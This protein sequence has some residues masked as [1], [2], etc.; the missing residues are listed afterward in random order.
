M[1]ELYLV[2]LFCVVLVTKIGTDIY[3]A[4]AK[5]W[6]I[7]D[8]ADGR[9]KLQ[10]EPIPVGGGVVIFIVMTISLFIGLF[11]KGQG[12]L[13]AV[14]PNSVFLIIGTSLLLT[15]TGLWDDKYGMKGR[16]KLL[17]QIL[18]S[19][20]IVAYAR[21]FSSVELFGYAINLGHLFYPIAIFWL[22][23]FINAV[24]LLDGADGVASTFGFFF[25]ATA[26]GIGLIQGGASTA[27]F[28]FIMAA[29]VLGFFFCNMPPA[30]IYL[31]DT[32]SMLIGFLAGIFLLNVCAVNR[33]EVKNTIHFIPAFA[34]AFLPICDSFLAVIRRKLTGRS[35]YFADR[36]HLHHRIQKRVGRGFVLLAVLAALQIPL[37]LGGIAGIYYDNDWIPLAAVGAVFFVL[38]ATGLFGRYEIMI[39]LRE[40]LKIFV[41]LFRCKQKTIYTMSFVTLDDCWEPLWNSILAQTTKNSCVFVSLDVNI[42]VLETE[43]I[44]KSGTTLLDDGSVA[45]MRQIM[46]V[47]LPILVEKNYCGNLQIQFDLD[48]ID[49]REALEM[50]KHLT[51]EAA[52]SV[53]AY[54]QQRLHRDSVSK[55]TA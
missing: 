43:Y 48:K 1:S 18:V 23:G 26:G 44:A 37:S 2:F 22:V 31:G 35:I 42:P 41:R 4:L 40:F 39:I 49:C 30:K 8:Q 7:V 24:N 54:V 25:F 12:D 19:T 32:G 3:A 52:E 6:R 15:L 11:Y 9:R 29:A 17:I 45:E 5:R 20:I 46:A 10:K 53:G 51:G 13:L 16:N 34:I 28:C 14:I 50:A 36:S 27:L 38:V 47:R 33:D 21:D 55:K